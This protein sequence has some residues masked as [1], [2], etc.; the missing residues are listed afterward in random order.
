[1]IMK[2]TEQSFD[3]KG[4]II[5]EDHFSSMVEQDISVKEIYNTNGKSFHFD[6]HDKVGRRQYTLTDLICSRIRARVFAANQLEIMMDE[7][8]RTQRRIKTDLSSEISDELLEVIEGGRM[9]IV[10]LINSY[11]GHLSN[12]ELVLN[13]YL[14]NSGLIQAYV[15]NHAYGA[16]VMLLEKTTKIEA[17]VNS[18]FGWSF[19]DEE[20]DCADSIYSDIDN[21]DACFEIEQFLRSHMTKR[22]FAR[23]EK[24][25]NE[26]KSINGDKVVKFLGSELR[27]MGFVKNSHNNLTNLRKSSRDFL[28]DFSGEYPAVN[29]FWSMAEH[30][31]ENV[32][33][34]LHKKGYEDNDAIR[35]R[36]DNSELVKK[37]S[38]KV[39][40]HFKKLLNAN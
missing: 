25:L 10:L 9:K 4:V 13:N 19:E 29:R 37:L 20:D 18:V 28:G 24:R 17:C 34:N 26:T 39:D 30:V 6:N 21:E 14:R 3:G 12:F 1:M 8:A 40:K 2:K 31:E 23:F 27:Q 22:G 15:A 36:L 33:R 32:R 16:S 7:E 38:E 5:I 35:L 11:G